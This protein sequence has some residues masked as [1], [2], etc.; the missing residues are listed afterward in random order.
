MTNDIELNIV[1]EKE[2]REKSEAHRV[3]EGIKLNTTIY[4][5]IATIELRLAEET[6]DDWENKAREQK[7]RNVD[8]ASNRNNR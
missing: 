2:I 4:D 3:K 6:L 8:D 7:N 1:S 5:K